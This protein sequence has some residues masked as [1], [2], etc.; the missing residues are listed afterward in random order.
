MAAR[1]LLASSLGIVIAPSVVEGPLA[2]PTSI[3]AL[4]VLEEASSAPASIVNF[5]WRSVNT[6]S[7]GHTWGFRGCF[8]GV[9][10]SSL[11]AV[12]V[13]IFQRIELHGGSNSPGHS[14]ENAGTDRGGALPML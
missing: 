4:A 12:K 14:C 5:H 8:K 9:I 3:G 10:T 7:S 6:A 13:V 11:K 1:T 2:V